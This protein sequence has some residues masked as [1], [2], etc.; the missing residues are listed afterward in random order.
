MHPDS[1][2]PQTRIEHDAPTTNLSHDEW[3][4]FVDA[5]LAQG[6]EE[7]ASIRADLKTNT[8]ATQRIDTATAEIV[9]FFESVKGAFKVLDWIGRLA[10]PQGFID[11]AATAGCLSRLLQ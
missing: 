1:T 8:E 2:R 10:R 6:G 4:A 5:R 7:M 9:S 11:A 3:R